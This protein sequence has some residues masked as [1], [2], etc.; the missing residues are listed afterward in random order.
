MELSQGEALHNLEQY[1]EAVEA[2]DRALALNK[3][4]PIFSINKSESLRA[5]GED[6]ASI[7][8]VQ[9]AI[10]ILEQ[11]ESLEGSNNIKGE[12]AVAL[13]L[14]GN[15]YRQ[16]QSFNKAIAAY[17]RAIEYSPNYFPALIGKGITLSRAKRYPKAE[18]EFK[19]MLETSELTPTQE[20][21]TW[22]YLGKTQ[23]KS[24]RYVDGIAAFER[25]I[26]L[27]PNY[28]I[29]KNAKQQCGS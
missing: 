10:E 1:P 2:F 18:S 26:E 15:G 28:V 27:N 9:Q 24:A 29:A 13:T 22:F 14:L 16:T 12:F 25:A 8:S 4:D 5:L 3:T 6:E 11:I 21:Q 17:E 19:Q 20:A 23:C 7:A